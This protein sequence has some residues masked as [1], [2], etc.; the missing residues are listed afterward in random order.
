MLSEERRRAILEIVQ[1]SG[2]VVVKDLSHHFNTTPVTIRKDLETLH[3]QGMVHRTHGG[4]LPVTNGALLDRSLTE[5]EKLYRKEKARIAQAAVK[6]VSEG[7]SVVL[8]SGSTTTMIAR[9]LRQ[10]RDLTVITNGLNIAAELAG[11]NV[12]VVLVGGVLR[13]ES[14][15]LV[16]PFA[17]E[18][19]RR[20]SADI[21]FLGVD[22]IDVS[23]GLTTPNTQEAQVNRI[24]VEISRRTVV[25][26]DASKFGRRSLCLIVPTT[27]V[28]QVITDDRISLQDQGQLER[29]G[30]EMTIV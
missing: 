14:F 19:L 9:G 10:F 5:K 23:F 18:T 25:V 21:L 16:G 8:D 1:T 22:G 6:L 11:S 30:V 27:A 13:K 15:S 17:E 26:S 28:Q 7:Q 29:A 4:A 3:S 24:M 12:E 2:R 20:L